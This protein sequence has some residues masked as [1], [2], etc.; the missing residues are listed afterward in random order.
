MKEEEKALR[1]QKREEVQ[2]EKEF[3]KNKKQAVQTARRQAKPSE[4][5]KVEL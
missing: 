2:R 3:E 1:Q 4:C 5:L